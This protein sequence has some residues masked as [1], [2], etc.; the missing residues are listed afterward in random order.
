M[1]KF[2]NSLIV[3]VVIT[4]TSALL[5]SSCGNDDNKNSS[6]GRNQEMR[7]K[8]NRDNTNTGNKDDS[9]LDLQNIGIDV[10]KDVLI[11]KDALRE[12][13]AGHKGFYFFGDM[14]PG[15][16]TN[17]NFE[18][19]S[20]K[21]DAKII[22]AMDGIIPFIKDQPETND[23]EVYLQSN[24]NSA[25]VIGYDHLINLKVKKGDKI[26]A[27]QVLGYPSPE[28]NGLYRFEIQIT[29]SQGDGQHHCPVDFLNKKV[30]SDIETKLKNMMTAWN[31]LNTEPIYDLTKQN[32][33]GCTK[34]VLTESEVPN[35]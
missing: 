6:N 1:Y 15:N 32:P 5:L 24:E 13:Q 23:N 35:N 2:K 11:T 17:P 29:Q 28:N 33:I 3:I 18:F 4:I 27:G 31:Q 25:W 20:V 7:D 10:E 8:G 19:A 12:Y 34:T 21:K 14:L 30:K 22:A 9:A 16:R 26:K